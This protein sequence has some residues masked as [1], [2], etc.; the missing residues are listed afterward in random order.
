LLRERL[1]LLRPGMED[2]VLRRLLD[3][4]TF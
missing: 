4:P 3:H 2:L 1:R